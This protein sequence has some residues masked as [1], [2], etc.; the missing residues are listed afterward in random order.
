MSKVMKLHNESSGL[1]ECRACGQL[2]LPSIKP[3]P[4]SKYYPE[5]WQCVHGCTMEDV[6]WQEEMEKARKDNIIIIKT[7]EEKPHFEREKEK[8]HGSSGRQQQQQHK[9]Y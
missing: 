8:S 7:I 4:G 2:H 9:S 1:M 3:K 6:R 5:N